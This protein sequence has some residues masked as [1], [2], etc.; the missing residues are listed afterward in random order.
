[1]WEALRGA[2]SGWLE[3]TEGGKLAAVFLA[4]AGYLLWDKRQR[5]AS[6]LLAA[7]GLAG[8]LLCICPVTAAILMKYY[9]LFY[10]YPWIWSMVP[11]T[12]VIALGGTCLLA[13]LWN[14]ERGRRGLARR[15]A[16]T[17]GCVGI[18]VLCGGTA[19]ELAD[20]AGRD[21]ALAAV[22]EICDG[23]GFC[24]WA[25]REILEY[26][27]S[28]HGEIRLLYG[29]NMWD[30]ALNAYSYDGYSEEEKELYEWMEHLT[31]Y[32]RVVDAGEGQAYVQRAFDLGAERILLP[33]RMEGWDPR[34]TAW[35]R[36][37]VETRLVGEYYLICL[38]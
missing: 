15:L 30:N 12:C 1:M 14:G 32:G 20:A 22:G 18:L 37:N 10:D 38:R 17:A 11:I 23:S 9:T 28:E 7:Y 34:D 8:A 25:P 31:D 33:G 5:G 29:R 27:R 36:E 6:R 2:W 21:Q 16:V 19:P 26:V 4:L 35:P 24:L 3:F 13:K